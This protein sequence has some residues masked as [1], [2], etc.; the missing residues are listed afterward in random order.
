MERD[1]LAGRAVPIRGDEI[2]RSIPE[3]FRDHLARAPGNIAVR[4]RTLELSYARLDAWSDAI[5]AQL[6]GR[7]D[8]CRE[9]VP[10]LLPQ[11]PLAIATTLGILKAGKFYVPIDPSWGPQRAASLVRELNARIL[12]TDGEFA[13]VV[14]DLGDAVV[15]ELPSD[16]PTVAGAPV[17]IETPADAPAYVYFTSGSTGRP[18]GVVDCHRNVLHNVMRYTHALRIGASDRLSLLQSCGF[19]GAVSS[20]FAALLNGATCCPVDMRA[21]TPARLARWLDEVSVTVYHSVPSLFRSMTAGDQVFPHVRVVRLEGDRATRLDVQLFRS[22]FA[23]HALLAIGL[24][25]TETGLVCQYFIDQAQAV[26]DGLVPIGYPVTDMSF[27]IR[28]DDARP[29]P[30]GTAGEIVVKSR[31]LAIGYWNDPETTARAFSGE[32]GSPERAYRTG[33]RGRMNDDGCLEY[34]GRLDGRVRIRGQWVEPADIDTALCSIAGVREAAVDVVGE[35]SGDARVVAYY[36]ADG[37]TFPAASELRRELA[38]RLPAHM[39]PSTLIRLER[40][41]LTANGK[42]DRAALPEAEPARPGLPRPV[43][44]KPVNLVQLRICEVWE[45]LLNVTPIGIRDDFFHLGGDSLL[46]VVML[47]RIEEI[48]GR[49][50]PTSDLI[51][52]GNATIER[53]AQVALTDSGE[54]A[55]PM[56][57]LPHG[58]GRPTLFFL[59][60]DYLSG[61]LY[62][63]E[64]V[65]HLR[66]A[67]PFVALPPWG[68]DGRPVPETYEAMAEQHLHAI[69]GV[70]PSGPYVLGGECNGGLVAYEIARR[71][72]AQGERVSLL[73]LLS[74]SAQNVRLRPLVSWVHLAGKLLALSSTKERYLLRRLGDFVAAQPTLAIGAVLGVLVRK[75]PHIVA[76]LGRLAL[77]AGPDRPRLEPGPDRQEGYRR[78]LAA[79]FQEIDQAYVPGRFGGRVTLIRGR[80]ERPDMITERTWW[81]SIAGNV[82]TF[83][84]PGDNRTK[85]TRHVGALGAVMDRLLERASSE[86]SSGVVSTAREDARSPERHVAPMSRGLARRVVVV[87]RAGRYRA[88]ND[89]LNQRV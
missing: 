35:E 50:I 59:H 58:A 19:S 10:F 14:R 13:P 68:F 60:G 84:V 9:P 81:Q 25:A 27:E 23:P 88:A 77:D 56:V 45:D 1:S 79:V 22:H 72:E 46:A 21:E 73:M 70:Q 57:T 64:L 76:E 3:R 2:E 61:G 30:P 33:D 78:R 71:L 85:L 38:G 28:G 16:I 63:R 12:L 36:V 42:V 18:K 86:T 44:V 8:E 29:V 6:L 17:H 62:C 39:V 37:P 67:Q 82:E 55:A 15:I 43:V 4:T 80:E 53:L 83:E 32:T 40:L 65:R 49:G 54:V 52:D 24:G 5:A 34:L 74:A 51:G 66:P 26:P 7:L 47:D 75:A 11:G 48:L 41:P 89:S 69:R 31:F 20:M 87:T